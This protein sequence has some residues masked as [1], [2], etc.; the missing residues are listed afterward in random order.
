MSWRLGNSIRLR[1]K[2]GLQIWVTISDSENINRAW[3]NNK[4]NIKISFRRSLGLYE[5]KQHQE[6]SDEER[7]RHL[8]QRKHAKVHWVLGP[9]QSNVDNLQ[10]VRREGRRHFRNIKK[11][12]LKDK[13]DELATNSK[14]KKYQRLV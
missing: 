10:N 1:S 9:K 12:Y 3:E 6:W 8:D 7:L 11:A 14:I 5:L 2:T 4:K 13:I